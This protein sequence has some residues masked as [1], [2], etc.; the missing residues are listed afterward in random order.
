MNENIRN[1]YSLWQDSSLYPEE[2]VTY[3]YIAWV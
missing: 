1:K 2:T 3:D